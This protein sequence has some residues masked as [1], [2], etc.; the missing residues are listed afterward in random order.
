MREP[1]PCR[2]Q[3]NIVDGGAEGT[4]RVCGLQKAAG[5][6]RSAAQ[7]MT[8]WVDDNDSWRKATRAPEIQVS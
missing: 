2:A 6:D 1:P 3:N 4:P 5:T 7:Q 8:H